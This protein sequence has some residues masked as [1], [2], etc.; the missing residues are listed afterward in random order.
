V[1]QGTIPETMTWSGQNLDII[2]GAVAL[3]AAPFAD[4]SRAAAWIANVVGAALL[5]NVAR[6]ATLSSPLP[7]AWDVEPKL[8]LVE[9]L[10]YAWIGSVCVAGAL[11]GHVILTRALLARKG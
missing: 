10:P 5:L 9:H 7:F 1:K 11:A 4:K 2:T 3:L 6:V 8:R